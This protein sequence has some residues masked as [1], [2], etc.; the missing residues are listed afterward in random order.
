[1]SIGAASFISIDGDGGDGI[2]GGE[3]S[4]TGF[5]PALDVLSHTGKGFVKGVEKT[6]DGHSTINLSIINK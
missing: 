6:L 5:I 2:G 3:R 1:M 4:L